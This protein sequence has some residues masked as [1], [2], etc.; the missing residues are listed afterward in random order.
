ML[1]TVTRGLV[2]VE[3]LAAGPASFFSLECHHHK[4][5]TFTYENI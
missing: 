5:I 4:I 3:V 2:K 1:S